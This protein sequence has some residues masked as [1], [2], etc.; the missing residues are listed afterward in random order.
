MQTVRE[1]NRVSTGDVQA[2]LGASRPAAINVLR[3]LEAEG[4]VE[5]IGNSSR[6]PRAYWQP[7]V[8]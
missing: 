2:A 4:L 1:G 7:R 8:E 6:D 3:A 5:W